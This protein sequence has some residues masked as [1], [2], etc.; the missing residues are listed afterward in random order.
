M[1]KVVRVKEQGD[2]KEASEVC[3]DE[4]VLS[5]WFILNDEQRNN[6]EKP[7]NGI[8]CKRQR[9]HLCMVKQFKGN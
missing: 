3:K 1:Q 2:E 8:H 9:P 5:N 4:F 7:L 6:E